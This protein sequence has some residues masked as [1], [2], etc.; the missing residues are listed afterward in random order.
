MI[1]SH[2]ITCEYYRYIKYIEILDHFYKSKCA[3]NEEE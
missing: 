1:E 3:T 2:K